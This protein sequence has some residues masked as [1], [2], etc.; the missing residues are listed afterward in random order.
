MGISGFRQSGMG[1]E[2]G[3]HGFDE[4]STLKNVYI[5]LKQGGSWV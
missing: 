4:Y 5:V 1:R 2:L 3:R